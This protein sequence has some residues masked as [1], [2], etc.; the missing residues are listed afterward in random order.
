MLGA[1]SFHVLRP[2]CKVVTDSWFLQHLHTRLC[3]RVARIYIVKS[4]DALRHRSRMY[5]VAARMYSVEAPVTFATVLG[6]ETII[7]I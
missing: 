6:Y 3:L 1:G 4:P 5:S 2:D 7:S